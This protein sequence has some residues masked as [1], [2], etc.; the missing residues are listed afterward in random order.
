MPKFIDIH[1]NLTANHFKQDLP[2]V[3]AR[4]REK[5]IW[6]IDAGTSLE[7]S[8]RAVKLAQDNEDIFATVG[9]HP[10]EAGEVFN[11]K[12]FED[13]V[14]DSNVVAIGECGLD[15]YRNDMSRSGERERQFNNLEAQLD[16]GAKHDKRVFLHCR[17]A[18]EDMIDLLASKK[19]EYRDK[20]KIHSHFFVGSM[21]HLK[22][23]LELEST[24]SFT[25]VV[26]FSNDYDEAVGYV[27]GDKIMIETD[28]PYAAPNPHRGK[29]NEPQYVELIAEHVA[30]IRGEDPEEFAKKT[31]ENAK[32]AF[33]IAV[34]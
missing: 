4:M 24:V 2:D 18:Y 9:I 13:L 20:L 5:D 10:N 34:S 23:L 16:F 17:D 30:N 32:I 21:D 14:Q 15:Y 22:A 6:V 7:T 26:T 31:V 11:E 8:R 33:S 1:T 25:G 29:Q 12:D 27:P 28:S 19:K 3:L